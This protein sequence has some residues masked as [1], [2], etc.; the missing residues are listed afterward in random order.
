[1][2]PGFRSSETQLTL[3]DAPVK[4]SGS[5]RNIA[6]N[7]IE[8]C[9]EKVSQARRLKTDCRAEICPDIGFGNRIWFECKCVGRTN[10][11]II[12]K[13]RLEKDRR[14]VESGES[15]YYWLWNHGA[16]LM[17]ADT[18]PA[19]EDRILY[20]LR[21]LTIVDHETLVS[22]LGKPCRSMNSMYYSN[23]GNIHKG[24][25]WALPLKEIPASKIDS[26][27]LFMKRIPVLA[28]CDIAKTFLKNKAL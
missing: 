1:M 8:K 14:F 4:S 20:S 12:Y 6:G 23:H 21:S 15:L 5:V 2:L 13:H 3:W 10:S 27:S 19:A 18:I 9:T 7:F 25:G 11:V 16:K 28:S 26:I 22:L 24:D 17:D